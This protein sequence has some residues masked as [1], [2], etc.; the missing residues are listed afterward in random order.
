MA[1]D[2]SA[3]VGLKKSSFEKFYSAYTGTDAFSLMTTLVKPRSRGEIKLRSKNIQDKPLIDPRYF[4]NEIDLKIMVE[5][6]KNSSSY[7]LLHK[8]L[9]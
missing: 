5:G 3:M 8:K 9:A 4:E 7:V 6:Y 2:I 1:D